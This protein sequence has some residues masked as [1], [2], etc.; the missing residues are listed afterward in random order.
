MLDRDAVDNYLRHELREPIER[1]ERWADERGLVRP[2]TSMSALTG[3]PTPSR[4]SDPAYPRG[5]S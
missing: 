5:M 1:I 4:W 3:C 2:G